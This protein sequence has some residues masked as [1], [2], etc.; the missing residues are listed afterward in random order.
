MP[1]VPHRGN[2]SDVRILWY[3]KWHPEDG[4]YA[5]LRQVTR[6]LADRGHTVGVV[7]HGPGRLNEEARDSRIEYMP[8]PSLHTDPPWT[9]ESPGT[10]R[11]MER[12]VAELSPDVVH[13][14]L[15][16]STLDL[17]LPTLLAEADVPYVVTFHV[18]FA[19]SVSSATVVSAGT[20]AM[21]RKVLGAASGVIA[22]GPEQ[23]G[24][25]RRFASV[26]DERIHEVPNGV[27]A[28]RFCPGTSEW[29]QS[30][31]ERFVVGYVGR[32]APEKN[33][34]ELC[35]GFLAARLEDARLV[36]V[37]PGQSDGLVRRFG[38]EPSITV[39]DQMTD[40]TAVADL[41]RGLDVFVLPSYIEGMSMSLLEAMAS[42]VV[43]VATDVGEHHSLVD[44]CGV[45]LQTTGIAEG[46][47][48]ALVELSTHPERRATLAEA[49]RAR[50]RRRGWDR[51][52]DAI[53][54]VYR[55]VT[56]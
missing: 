38:R 11:A 20:Y 9:V 43:P 18:S 31:R 45:L 39:L 16:I 47:S 3:G 37:G 33:L 30:V 26:D 5:Y 4:N 1:I 15:P 49:A 28:V 36:I 19:R 48:R 14:S 25:L 52:T 27:N 17:R 53:V 54:E 51:T 34:D 50:A 23:R 56:V 10:A 35:K 42:G 6:R 8:L 7:Y 24:W 12:W 55:K 13:A 21:Y 41:M 44:G 29:R 32:R 46:V 2:L 22:F 40:R